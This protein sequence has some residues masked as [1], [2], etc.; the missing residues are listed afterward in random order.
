[1]KTSQPVL[2]V[3]QSGRVNLKERNKFCIHCLPQLRKVNYFE[4]YASKGNLK[5][6]ENER[7]IF[8]PLFV[9]NLSYHETHYL[10]YFYY[11]VHY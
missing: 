8:F 3:K 11:Y 10:I 5:K 7:I 1:M 9:Q 4:I 6:N 2:L